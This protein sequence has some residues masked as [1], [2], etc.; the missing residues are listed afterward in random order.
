MSVTGEL[1]SLESSPDFPHQ[2]TGLS[3]RTLTQEELEKLRNDRVLVSDFKQ[4]KLEL[5]AQ[6]NWDLFYKRNTTNFFKDRH[7]TT[8]EF[9]EL[10]NC[11][12]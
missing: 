2:S 3:E 5:E 6:K 10:K 8:R 11:R 7:W 9:D 1:D 12:E 4:Q